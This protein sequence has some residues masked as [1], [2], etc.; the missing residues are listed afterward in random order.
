MKKTI[1][2]LAFFSLSLACIG[3]GTTRFTQYNDWENPSVT[4]VNTTQ[5]SANLTSHPIEEIL[6]SN[7]GD[8]FTNYLSLNGV[9]YFNWVPLPDQRPIDFYRDEFEVKNWD[10]IRVPSN[11]QM[12]GYGTPIYT[13]I[14][15]PFEKNPPR[16]I[17][18]N[19]NPVGS[20][21]RYFDIPSNW[22]DKEIF[23]RLDGVESAFYIWING[24]KVGYAQDS[25]TTAEFN[26]TRFL[27]PNQNNVSVQVF[28]WCD[29]SYLE[30]QDFWRLSGIY[31]DIYLVARPQVFFE[32]LFIKTDFDTD[33][34]DANLD[35]ELLLNNQVNSKKFRGTIEFLLEDMDSKS[36]Q[37]NKNKMGIKLAKKNSKTLS[38]TY[39]IHRPKPW[40]GESPYLYSLTVI[41]RDRQQNII[42]QIS[43]S[44]GFREVTIRDRQIF[45]NDRPL[46]IKGVNRHEHN[47]E[48]GHYLSRS[49]MEKEVQLMKQL[50]INTVR[51]AHYPA[52]PYFYDLCDEYGIYVIDEA[53]VESH[54]MRYG[55]ESLAKHPAWKK[56][57]VE[58]MEYMV[59]QNKN[60]PSIIMWSLGNEAGNGINMKA[61]DDAAHQIDDTRPT[62]YHFTNAPFVGD[63]LGGGV[64]KNGKK[65][66]F[67]RY[68]TVQDLI[69][70]AQLE[71]LDRPFIV[72]EFA[73]AM[74]N[75]CGNLKEYVDVF[76]EYDGISGG[77][78]W[79][80]VDQGLLKYTDS[81][82]PFYAYGGDYGDT[83]NDLNFCLNG[84]L[85]SDLSLSP[86]AY[87]VKS[88][89]QPIDA[90]I[91]SKNERRIV[92]TNKHLFTNLK[93]YIVKWELLSNGKSVLSS[94]LDPLDIPPL[95]NTSVEIPLQV[96]NKMKGALGEYF[97]NVG[98]HLTSDQKWARKGY[99]V[100]ACQIQ[101]QSPQNNPTTEITDDIDFTEDVKYFKVQTDEYQVRINKESGMVASLHLDNSE[102]LKD[103]MQFN[104]WRAPTDNDGCD[105]S[106]WRKNRSQA[107]HSW[108]QYG[109]DSTYLQVKNIALSNSSQNKIDI[110]AELINRNEESIAEIILNYTFFS[111]NIRLGTRF[112][113]S[114]N[115]P[116]LPRIGYE[117]PI[118]SSLKYF[119]W[120][121]RGPHE[122]YID[123]NSSAH[124][125]SYNT[126]VDDLF[127]NYPVPQE[128]GNRTGIR[129][130]AANSM[131]GQG[132]KVTAS[133]H[134]EFSARRYGQ[135]N[136]TSANHTYELSPDDKIYWYIDYKQNGLG[137]NSCGPKPLEPYKLR[138]EKMEF[139]FTINPF[140][141]INLVE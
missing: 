24:Q 92:L 102:I 54:G 35:I 86:K 20:Y 88:C 105:Q 17:G 81:G 60:H 55:E 123:R 64:F 23:L 73:H 50:N 58:R 91:D 52:S 100:A 75:A 95:K 119:S 111:S 109:L 76:D 62:H 87:E 89:Y 79:D 4:R 43:S 3:L 56:A 141:E 5:P 129:W 45:L 93:T 99:P 74:G 140:K 27:K 9:W 137:G 83:P 71:N 130:V 63:V 13:N 110:K 116:V 138:P 108:I 61:M 22:D 120:Y 42:D 122:N 33:Y 84:I 68:H 69:K 128:N 10:T 8:N 90:E 59:H 114:E 133:T 46:I 28:R 65:N 51:N 78:I 70:I 112:I 103:Q 37:L 104:I 118:D 132:V 101:L 19:G 18:P 49:Q 113:P 121:G 16:I 25:R 30:D 14:E 57:H 77:C 48:T 135:R 15:Y 67:G 44:V 34:Q 94:V 72:N 11:W 6:S 98:V 126:T 12:K 38:T 32:D 131:N 39:T 136:L 7:I 125:G 21:K 134:F 117:I 97:L 26:I 31:R 2:Y 66:N 106:M 47:P 53:N 139:E 40:S 127:V 85:F 80:W 29:G 96:F 115:L 41:L 107:V 1:K 36:I 82:E 124:V